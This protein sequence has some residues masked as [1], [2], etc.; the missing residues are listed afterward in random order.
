[1]ATHLVIYARDDLVLGRAEDVVGGVGAA[2]ELA[3]LLGVHGAL[4]DVQ[5]LLR[6]R[7]RPRERARAR[8]SARV[9]NFVALALAR[10]QAGIECSRCRARTSTP[11]RA[12]P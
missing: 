1:M 3:I 12:R 11:A 8:G 5:E 10:A 2:L 4:H 6:A 7:Q 9:N